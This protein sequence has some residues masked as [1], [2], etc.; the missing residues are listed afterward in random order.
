M[1]L[2]DVVGNEQFYLGAEDY[3]AGKPAPDC[4]LLAAS[5]AAVDP[6][7]VLVIEDSEVGIRAG[8]SAGM[9]V[10]ATHAAVPFAANSRIESL[11]VHARIHRLGEINA[12]LVARLFDC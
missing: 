4:Y 7:D 9:K 12:E 8:L 6:A 3:A 2:F 5:R 11:A 1:T 10:I